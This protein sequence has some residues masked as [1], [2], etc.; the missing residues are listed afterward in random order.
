MR[1]DLMRVGLGSIGAVTVW[2][3]TGS[4]CA[5][6]PAPPVSIAGQH[7]TFAGTVK[8]VEA[9]PHAALFTSD[10]GQDYVLDLSQAKVVLPA[11]TK[12]LQPGER[13][14]VSGQGNSDG[15]I[16]VTRFQIL[17]PPPAPVPTPATP[18]PLDLTVRG[19][20]E[21][22]NYALGSF[23]LRVNTHTRTVFVTPDTDI[24]GLGP[25]AANGFPVQPGRRVTV[26]GSLQPNGTLLAGVLT[27]KEDLDYR[28]PPSLSNRVLFGTVSSPANKLRGRDFRLRLAE[29]TET[30]I[31]SSRAIPVRRSGR[32][33]SVYDL[34][35]R[36][37][38]RLIGRLKG[39][40]FEAARIDV[41]T[42]PPDPSV[43]PAARPG[44]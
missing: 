23:V 18:E 42:S 34:N 43:V 15:S 14:Y 2:L 35:R 27:D 6:A 29:G 7:V 44:L 40:D 8:R 19:T 22:V 39:T 26:G 33:I 31:N 28:T 32:Q 17:P 10:N 30:K 4:V 37:M 20:V 41:L 25:S 13:G 24:V 1:S 9:G 5:A 12:Q 3:L 16:A 21:A 38:V 11:G 36:D